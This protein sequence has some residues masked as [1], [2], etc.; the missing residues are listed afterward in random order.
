M[1][2]TPQWISDLA[3]YARNRPQHNS[4]EFTGA[5]REQRRDLRV[6]E[7]GWRVKSLPLEVIGKAG[8]ARSQ[9]KRAFR[10]RA[11]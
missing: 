10:R 1:S 7:S 6:F 9:G 11:Q 4:A 3:E 2:H 5:N 8:F